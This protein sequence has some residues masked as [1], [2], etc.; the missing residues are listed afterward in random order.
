MFAAGA[1][2]LFKN[3]QQKLEKS[4]KMQKLVWIVF[5]SPVSQGLTEISGTI[6]D[7]EI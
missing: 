7:L 5:F 2:C 1:G 3:E 4:F 6:W